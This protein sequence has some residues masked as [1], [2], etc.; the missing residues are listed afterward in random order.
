MRGPWTLIRRAALQPRY[1]T[2]GVL[3][4]AEG[5]LDKSVGQVQSAVGKAKDEARKDF[6][7]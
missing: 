2:E 7:H 4:E 3:L 5:K 6:K 1:P